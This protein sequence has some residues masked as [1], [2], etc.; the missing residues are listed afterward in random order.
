M[1]P[2]KS[3][4]VS[5]SQRVSPISSFSPTGYGAIAGTIASRNNSP[6]TP[7]SMETAF[8]R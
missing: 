8:L 5:Q 7:D 6:E 2:K 1:L 4:G 3:F